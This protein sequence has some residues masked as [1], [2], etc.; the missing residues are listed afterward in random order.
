MD[1][2]CLLLRALYGHP[3]AGCYWEQHTE[4]HLSAVGF[5]PIMD[6]K[7]SFGQLTVDLMLI[8]YVDDFKLAG[9]AANI[10]E[11]WRLSRKGIIIGEPEPIGR[12]LGCE[13]RM[14]N[15]AISQGSNPCHGDIPEPA[16]KVKN[17]QT[18]L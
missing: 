4:E 12:Y 11:A 18:F 3:A 1:P 9:L 13:H 14:V 16:P 2:V 10:I 8:V 7:T 6:W 15:A 5:I 17:S